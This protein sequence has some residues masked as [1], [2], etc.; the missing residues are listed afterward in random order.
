MYARYDVCSLTLRCFNNID[1]S[2]YPEMEQSILRQNS[3]SISQVIQRHEAEF[4]VSYS[5]NYSPH[6]IGSYF[7]TRSYALAI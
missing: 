6:Y 5:Y 4:W 7:E 1:T 2:P 3:S